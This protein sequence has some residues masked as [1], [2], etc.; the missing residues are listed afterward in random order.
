MID[1]A[2]LNLRDGDR[3]K[4]ST[5]TDDGVPREYGGVQVMSY[6]VPER[7]VVGYYPEC[8]V[9]TALALRQRKQGACVKIHSGS[10]RVA[11]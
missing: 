11:T 8:N 2:K 7:C 3:V 9:L 10:D 6:A 4:L 1:I 5:A